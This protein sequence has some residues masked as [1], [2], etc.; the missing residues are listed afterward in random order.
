[1]PDALNPDGSGPCFGFD[2]PESE[3]GHLC[4]IDGIRIFP[5]EPGPFVNLDRGSY[6]SNTRRAPL[7]GNA[8]L[9]NFTIRKQDYTGPLEELAVAFAHVVRDGDVVEPPP[10]VLD[11]DDDGVPDHRDNCIEVANGPLIPDLGGN[12]QL[13][14]DRDGNGNACDCDFDQNGF[15]NIADFTIFREDFIATV[16]RGVGTDMDG[17]GAV[18]IADFSLFREGFRA[19]VPGPSGLVP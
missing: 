1:L 3:H 17:N 15:C 11:A 13:D 9:F 19:T 4:W 12:S 8:W 2:C 16:D 14:S 7:P 5:P 10:T 18:S 6:W